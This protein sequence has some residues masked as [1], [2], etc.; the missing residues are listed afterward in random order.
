MPKLINAGKSNQK[1]VINHQKE[2][3]AHWPTPHTPFLYAA[4]TDPD[5]YNEFRLHWEP[6]EKNKA[7]LIAE[8]L[9][10]RTGAKYVVRNIELHKD[11]VRRY[12]Y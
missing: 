10:A 9:S 4:E 5:L 8:R 1:W 2:A 3:I 6:H 11:A 12:S 7:E